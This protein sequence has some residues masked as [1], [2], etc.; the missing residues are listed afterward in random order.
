MADNFWSLSAFFFIFSVAAVS[1]IFLLLSNTVTSG[2]DIRAVW[3][4]LALNGL[5]GLGLLFF[6]LSRLACPPA[7][8]P[9]YGGR[10]NARQIELG[11]FEQSH[12]GTLYLD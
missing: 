4:I 7:T 12:G 9:R 10:A 5:I 1:A 2:R 6:R 11:L 3:P 8:K